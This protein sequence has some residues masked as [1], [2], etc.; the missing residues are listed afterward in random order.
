VGVGDGNV[1]QPQQL[2]QQQLQQDVFITGNLLLDQAA[3]IGNGLSDL[4]PGAPS[5]GTGGGG[6]GGGTGTP[7]TTTP[8]T[9]TPIPGGGTAQYPPQGQIVVE[10]PTVDVGGQVSFKGSGC[11]PNE[12]LE[13]LFDGHPIGTINADTGGNFAGSITI[14]AGTAPGQH[15]L[16]VHGSACVLNATIT[17]AGNLAFTGSSSHTST[18]VLGGMAAVVV[19]MVLVVGS[20]RRRRGVRGRS[21]PPPALS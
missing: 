12:P 2:T 6:G 10:N 3:G 19:G 8:P 1:G 18:Y 11:L 9:T 21:S 4:P 7:T 16:T 14:P 15:L 20:R 17:V 13:I 5:G